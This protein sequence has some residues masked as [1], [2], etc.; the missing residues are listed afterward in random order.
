MV[1]TEQYKTEKAYTEMTLEG[2][3]YMMDYIIKSPLDGFPFAVDGALYMNGDG[4]KQ[5]VGYAS[6]NDG[7][8]SIRMESS[9]PV[10]VQQSLSVQF[11]I[12]VKGILG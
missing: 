9:V 10:S 3:V 5:R 6:Y 1:V 2:N 8:T 11:F 4:G 12:D 7:V